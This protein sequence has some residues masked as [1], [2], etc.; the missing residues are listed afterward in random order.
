M[1][2]HPLNPMRDSNLVRVLARQSRH[3]VGLVDHATVAAGPEAILA[4]LDALAREGV[5][6]AIADAIDEADLEALGRVAVGRRLS[7]GASGIGI[8]VARAF[9]AAGRTAGAAGAGATVAPI[10][11]PALCLAGSCSAATLGQ[12]AEAERVMPVLRLDVDALMDGTGEVER[13]LAFVR[14]RIGD[15][16]VLVASSRTPAE[17]AAVQARHGRDAAGHAVEAAMAL[18]AAELTGDGVRRIVVAG[19][20]TSGAVVERLGIPAFRIGPEIA[21]GVPVLHAVGAPA[22]RMVLALKS[23]NFGKPSFFADALNL[24]P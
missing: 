1:K 24:M 14:E 4:R 10:G 21:A 15:G 5:R 18:I 16:P 2:D 7:T 20:E 13:A 19:G 12:I 23:G 11:G 17:V 6:A 8:G 22:G 3:K 9:V